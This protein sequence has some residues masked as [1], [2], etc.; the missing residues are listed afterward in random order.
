MRIYRQAGNIKAAL[1]SGAIA[2]VA[3][4]FFYTQ[5]IIADLRKESRDTVSLYARLIAKG[6]TEVSDSE[7]EFVFT[8]IIQKVTF[9]VIHTDS[10]GSP[11]NWQDVCSVFLFRSRSQIFRSRI[12]IDGHFC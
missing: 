10:E 9:P 7:L 4:L 5:S 1:F 11:I 2:L 6:V 8:E 3:G 12:W